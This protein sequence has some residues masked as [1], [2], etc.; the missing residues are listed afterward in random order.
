VLPRARRVLEPPGA[1]G[2]Q[3]VRVRWAA[4]EMPLSER[5]SLAKVTWPVAE[6]PK[7]L[8]VPQASIS[9]VEVAR[10]VEESQELPVLPV[11]KP[12]TEAKTWGS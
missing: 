8:E 3:V 7:P 1:E 12:E 9:G 2:S 10:L 5:R 11:L 6:R 4:L